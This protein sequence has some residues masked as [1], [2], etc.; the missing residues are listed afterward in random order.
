L[1]KK[2][3]IITPYT[4]YLILEDE[5]K[6]L[7]ENRFHPRFRLLNVPE[8]EFHNRLDKEMSAL[9]EKSG[10]ASVQASQEFDALNK[11]Q[12]LPQTQQGSKRL[13]YSSN[14]GK[15]QNLTQQIKHIFGR[16][17]FQN[18]EFWIDSQLQTAHFTKTKR[19]KI[20]SKEYIDLLNTFEKLAPVLALGNVRFYFNDTFYEIQY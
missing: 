4:S 7:A 12:N 15:Q 10:A 8:P 16:A 13:N 11:V 18:G 5:M 1:A 9:K 3:G 17:F 19:I 6:Q 2:H 20:G 14:A